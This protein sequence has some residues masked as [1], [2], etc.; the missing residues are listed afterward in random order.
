VPK[1]ITGVVGPVGELGVTTVPS[2]CAGVVVAGAEGA[3]CARA[4]TAAMNI[5]K[6]IRENRRIKP[7]LR[8]VQQLGRIRSSL[9]IGLLFSN[10]GCQQLRLQ[11]S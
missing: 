11:G 9:Q 7:P 6:K 3:V 1:L 4:A 10:L 8:K 5:I 2:T